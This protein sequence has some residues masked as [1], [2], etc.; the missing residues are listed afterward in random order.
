MNGSREYSRLLLVAC[1]LL[2]SLIKLAQ[3]VDRRSSQTEHLTYAFHGLE[4][5]YSS[6]IMTAI[7]TDV[8][9]WYRLALNSVSLGAA[10]ARHP[11]NSLSSPEPTPAALEISIE[12]AA[13]MLFHFSTEVTMLPPDRSFRMIPVPFTVNEQMLASFQFAIDSY[14]ITHA[15]A[16]VFLA[17]AYTRAIIDGELLT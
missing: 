11:G 5:T 10:L 7:M 6:S 16:I 17:L 14:W 15:F 8:S 13:Q 1:F 9:Q 3:N 2:I 4:G 12:A